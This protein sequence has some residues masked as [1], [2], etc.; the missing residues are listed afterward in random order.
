[1]AYVGKNTAGVALTTIG[2]N[3]KRGGR[4]QA[5]STFTA[6]VMSAYVRGTYGGEGFRCCIYADSSGDPGALLGYT[7]TTDAT[8]TSELWYNAKLITPV[9][10][11]SG[12]YYWLV[13][14]SRDTN[15]QPSVNASGG[16]SA[17]A[18]SSDTFSDGPVDPFG[19][20]TS[21][22]LEYS[23]YASDGNL[24]INAGDLDRSG[25]L[26]TDSSGV[27]W[28][29][30]ASS[31]YLYLY[32]Y[33]DTAPILVASALSTVVHG[34]GNIGQ[35]AAAIDSSD[36]IHIVSACTS[37]QTRDVAYT[38][39]G[40]TFGYFN[41]ST[42][43]DPDAVWTDDAL[44]FND[45]YTS[46]DHAYTTTTGSSSANYIEGTGTNISSGS[47]S[48]SS[49][50]I[51]SYIT[52][53]V[54]PKYGMLNITYSGDTLLNQQ[55]TNSDFGGWFTLTPPT[56]GW[57]WTAVAGMA[58]RVW[59]TS[60]SAQMQLRGIEV[61]V[62]HEEFST[63]GWVEVE[64]YTEQAPGNPGCSISLD[65]GDWPHFLFVD[66]VKTGGSTQDNV[67]YR[68]YLYTG[69]GTTTQIGIRS[70]KT[71][72]YHSPSI[73]LRGSNY[74][75]VSYHGQTTVYSPASFK[76][77][78]TGSWGSET[79]VNYNDAPE[80]PNVVATTG[81]TVY[82][83]PVATTH[84]YEDGNDTGY[85]HGVPNSSSRSSPVLSPADGTTRYIFFINV[86]YDVQLISNSGS[87]WSNEG[88]LQ[89]G[90]FQNVIAE[91][92]YN[93]EN[94]SGEINYIFTDGTS[95]YFDVFTLAVEP[96]PSV[97]D[98]V[99]VSD[100]PVV[101]MANLA[102]SKSES[103]GVQDTPVVDV[104]AD[105]NIS[106][107]DNVE[108][109]ESVSARPELSVATNQSVTVTEDKYTDVISDI[110]VDDTIGVVDTPQLDPIAISIQKSEGVGVQD[111]PAPEIGLAISKSELVSISEDTNALLVVV[112]ATDDSIGIN[113]SPLLDP[114]AIS[115]QKD[116]GIGVQDTPSPELADLVIDKSDSVLVTDNET[117]DLVIDISKSESV[118][119]SEDPTASIPIGLILDQTISV[120]DSPSVS[121]GAPVDIEVF[122]SVSV[123]EQAQASVSIE[124]T[125]SD[126][127]NAVDALQE[128]STVIT[129]QKSD[130][131]GVVE[132]TDT[133]LGIS[134]TK[135]EG[136]TLAENI[137]TELALAISVDDSINVNDTPYVLGVFQIFVSETPTVTD[138]SQQS[139]LCE[140]DRS[141]GVSVGDSPTM[142]LINSITVQ[143]NV[144]VTDIPHYYDALIVVY[145]RPVV[146]VE[147]PTGDRSIFK[148]E[149]INV[150]DQGSAEIPISISVSENI[151]L[152]EDATP[153]V[154]TLIIASESI[155][156]DEQVIASVQIWA[157][158]SE[159]VAVD[160]Y[161]A[162]TILVTISASETITVV[163]S[164]SAQPEE[165]GVLSISK[166][167]TIGVA[168]QVTLSVTVAATADESITTTDSAQL[169]IL[170]SIATS[171]GITV[172]EDVTVAIPLLVSKQLTVN[173]SSLPYLD[174]GLAIAK[175]E[176]VTVQ[177]FID[178]STSEAGAVLVS[179]SDTV[180]VADQ[181]YLDIA[182]AVSTSSGITITEAPSAVVALT[183]ARSD[184][185]TVTEQ[186]GVETIVAVSTSEG[187]AVA[188]WREASVGVLLAKAES[189]LVQESTDITVEEVGVISVSVSD[190]V[191]I[192]DQATT[193][194]GLALTSSDSI[195]ISDTP[196]VTLI[197]NIL[198]S[199]NILVED[200][201]H[202]YDALI[203]V[204]ERAIV[205]IQAPAGG[206]TASETVGVA[207]S[208]ELSITVSAITSEVVGVTESPELAATIGIV[209]QETAS[210]TEHVELNEVMGVTA[211]EVVSVT[212]HTE[213]DETIESRITQ[214]I[215]TSDTA[216][217]SVCTDI[218]V[219]S[220]ISVT[221]YV[222]STIGL[223]I[224]DI[225]DSITIGE[226]VDVQRLGLL[227]IAVSST[228]AVVDSATVV[229]AFPELV[230]FVAYIRRKLDM[231]LHIDRGDS[232]VEHIA[233]DKDLTSYIDREEDFIVHVARDEEFEVRR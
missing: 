28:M 61:Q 66:A 2:A 93:N 134:T 18:V 227:L 124:I 4:F 5:S 187:V 44:G 229:L 88:T 189:V 199:E 6:T 99:N 69:W 62:F 30:F 11:T 147:T 108:A 211:L 175:T 163:D 182:L 210:L 109:Q 20:Y 145:D 36:V 54:S 137:D 117:I 116:D 215:L 73:T 162:A 64:S 17:I 150:T 158:K 59:M 78:Y 58:A 149:T 114:I 34:G 38:T 3:A 225:I 222:G 213:L 207:E 132:N 216:Q 39:F 47:Q 22:V 111:I 135:S 15:T 9:D 89:T 130:G 118:G 159:P 221:E 23:I 81:G 76:R 206:V 86:S 29:V 142:S 51:R 136:V 14:H 50:R 217:P 152:T 202:Y 65:S 53:S 151:L 201:P 184:A 128:V 233:R 218:V 115:I 121:T 120:I 7:Y 231:I 156:A 119:I 25:D 100:T 102:I 12:N 122:D 27:K 106:V 228:I 183:I 52:F 10:I 16:T 196:L 188:E 91:W 104:L 138:S 98:S 1:M 72:L 154:E 209:A 129:I 77:S 146:E 42:P 179:V 169:E 13:I 92:A 164:G 148:S 181:Q 161:T 125:T 140:I 107:S 160:E 174:I 133:E 70:T 214:A 79:Y 87:G 144:S 96:A 21:G 204:L 185:T 223:S 143:D 232:V 41:D 157:V 112:I 31:S 212:E 205:D 45:T 101:E 220:P 56:G 74:I 75:E 168:S 230:E 113:D 177:E 126:N 94:Q 193:N 186:V 37:E 127:I 131:V 194:V 200:I 84:L 67:F 24:I 167:E 173:V 71:D 82:T 46:P 19:S 32:K 35:V 192:V 172:D 110:S 55:V 57:T 105:R 48:I 198:V 141:D 90:T 195:N 80:V 139:I 43:S 123:A 176:S 226:F 208:I 203:A 103:V 97:S 170:L 33:A 26:F 153:S 190:N 224:Q 95:V 219:A 49:V 40:A 180:G 191:S 85:D 165:A 68:N 63:A 197:F 166:D 8:T 60:T 83:Y 171:D 155:T 178:A